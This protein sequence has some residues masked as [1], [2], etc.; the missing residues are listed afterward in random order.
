MHACAFIFKRTSA[1]KSQGL[2]ALK[3]DICDL[4]GTTFYIKEIT[5]RK[6][7]RSQPD[8]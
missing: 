5:F 8:Q 7:V 4:K 3:I 1:L 2:P 6:R